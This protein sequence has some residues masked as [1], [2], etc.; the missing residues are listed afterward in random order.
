ML[1]RL[2]LSS[3]HRNDLAHD[4]L[5]IR[6][7]FAWTQI[8]AGQ[9]GADKNLAGACAILHDLIN[10]PKESAQR[11]RAAAL[12]AEAAQDVLEKAGYGA[13]EIAQIK[14][15]IATSNWS[16]QKRPS[17]ALGE[18]LQDADRLDAIGA[19]GI[20][21]T[22][23]TAQSMATRGAKLRLYAPE[24]P[25]GAL[26][27][28]AQDSRYA[29]DHF[30]AKLLTLAQGMH[31]PGAQEEAARRHKVMERYL[32]ELGRELVDEGFARTNR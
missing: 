23:A 6:R 24:D 25:F 2:A 31:T 26:G 20:A 17:S 5:H 4:E 8:L 9:E 19:I 7:V 21:R 27:R 11:S 15:A 10:V 3:V 18:I 1:W 14:E 29:L 22:F 28:D 30:R 13:N 12:S 32:D 16:A